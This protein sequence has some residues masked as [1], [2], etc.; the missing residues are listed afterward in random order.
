VSVIRNRLDYITG[1][2]KIKVNNKVANVEEAP[3]FILGNEKSGT[4]VI[5]DLL[6]KACDFSVTLDIPPIWNPVQLDIHGNKDAL[7]R[8]VQKN[9]YYFSNKIIKEPVLTFEYESLKS[10]FPA[11]KFIMIVRDPRYNIKSILNR[12][13]ILGNLESFDINTI[14][15]TQKFK[16]SWSTVIHNNWLG[17][18]SSHYIQSMAMRWNYIV[19]IYLNH[20]D[21]FILMR[22]EDFTTNKED[23]IATHAQML[24]GQVNSAFV[25][26]LNKQYQVAGNKTIT[27]ED[28]FGSK[29][30][31]TINS[32]CGDHMKKLDYF[33]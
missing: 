33:A 9:K 31:E 15:G 19:D 4:T 21:D 26:F 6:A 27:K 18:D 24:N 20:K 8:L 10:L 2:V 7:W 17:F 16:K 12:L 13:N 29:N 28:F 30:L 1:L 14:E 5:A 11:A 32:I 23:Y 22:Y 3:I 25:K